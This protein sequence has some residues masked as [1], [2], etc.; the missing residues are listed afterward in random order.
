MF[1]GTECKCQLKISLFK[2]LKTSVNTGICTSVL[3]K[4]THVRIHIRRASLP[5]RP[6]RQ[7]T[8]R[9]A[10]FGRRTPKL[11]FPYSTSSWMHLGS[12]DMAEEKPVPNCTPISSSAQQGVSANQMLIKWKQALEL[13][14]SFSVLGK[15]MSWAHHLFYQLLQK[16]I[17]HFPVLPPS[18]HCRFCAAEAV[19]SRSSPRQ[20]LLPAPG[21]VG[22]GWPQDALPML[23]GLH[24]SLRQQLPKGANHSSEFILWL[25]SHKN[26]LVFTS[27]TQNTI[28][29]NRKNPYITPGLL[30][31]QDPLHCLH[32]LQRRCSPLPVNQFSWSLS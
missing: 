16:Q 10:H 5:F 19:L 3:Q 13:E 20:H 29:W 27:S 15:T 21:R 31:Q 23:L 30:A 2:T 7:P 6:Q 32:G 4:Q 17:L 18:R 1:P 8:D 28:P 24:T 9:R 25:F 14:K 12:A 26:V 11:W 22:K